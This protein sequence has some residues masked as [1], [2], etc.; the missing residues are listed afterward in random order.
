MMMLPLLLTMGMGLYSAFRSS[1]ANRS[2]A[3]PGAPPQWGTP[4]YTSEPVILEQER[5][6][7]KQ[8]K[9]TSRASTNVTGGLGSYPTLGGGGALRAGF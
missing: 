3:E 1:L 6:R 5:M 8:A 9:K 2:E 7:N 4:D